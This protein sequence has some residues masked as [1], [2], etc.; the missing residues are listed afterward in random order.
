MF[1]TMLLSRKKVIIVVVT[2]DLVIS[3]LLL[4]VTVKSNFK[5][6]SYHVT[7]ID[8]LLYHLWSGTG[9]ENILEY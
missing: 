4:S 8:L 2:S 7:L 9:G 5:W 1:W 6:F 3:E